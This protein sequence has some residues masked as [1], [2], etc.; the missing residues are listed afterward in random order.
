[1]GASESVGRSSTSLTDQG[2]ADLVVEDAHPVFRGKAD[3]VACLKR[4]LDAAEQEQ[5]RLLN[6]SGLEIDALQSSSA[7]VDTP[8]K[9]ELVSRPLVDQPAL[10][11]SATLFP[12]PLHAAAA[13]IAPLEGSRQ[14]ELD[15]AGQHYARLELLREG[16]ELHLFDSRER[17]LR[18][19]LRD[20]PD[21][22]RFDY[23]ASG[24][25]VWP[26]TDFLG[27]CVSKTELLTDYHVLA[28]NCQHYSRNLV[29][30][31]SHHLLQALSLAG[32]GVGAIAGSLPLLGISLAAWAAPET[33]RRM[34]IG[35]G[36]GQQQ[37]APAAAGAGRPVWRRRCT[38]SGRRR[39]GTRPPTSSSPPRPP[40]RR[41]RRPARAAPA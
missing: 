29:L 8:C 1:M 23:Q 19:R 25:H 17:A 15:P 35:A 38:W 11:H 20:D 13:A 5:V 10:H 41:R 34:G 2:S 27:R 21:S 33:L 7:C 12:V 3:V 37:P 31:N 32:V 30:D 4:M 40:P 36:G 9:A 39:R 14:A 6:E 26:L 16:L 18:F 24:E 28:N 22:V